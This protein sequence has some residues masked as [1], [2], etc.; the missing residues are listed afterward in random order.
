SLLASRI[1]EALNAIE[2]IEPQL[3]DVSP[4]VAKR[5]RSATDLLRAACLAFQDD[6]I[7]ALTIAISHLK[8]SGVNQDHHAASTLCRLGSW[9]LAKFDFFY[10]LP[11]LQPGIRWSKSRAISTMLDLSI[12]AAAALDHLN[13]S[14]AKRLAS[15][16]LH[17]TETVLKETGGF[18]TLP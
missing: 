16:A 14:T 9:Q 13:V 10:S 1:D 3:D 15:D 6:S 8:E 12:E 4:I 17:I 2:R 5:F 11:R 7:A 18:A